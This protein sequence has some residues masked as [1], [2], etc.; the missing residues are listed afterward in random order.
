MGEL[1]GRKPLFPGDDYIKQMN[2]IFDTLGT[3][4]SSDL[5]FISN[6]KALEYIKGL[7]KKM[8]KQWSSI[9]P[10]ANPAAL[11]LLDKMLVFNPHQRITIDEALAHPYLKQLHNPKTE[12]NSKAKFD[13]DFEKCDLNKG[14]IQD[15]MWQEVL[16]F[17]PELRTRGFRRSK[18]D[19]TVVKPFENEQETVQQYTLKHSAQYQAQTQNNQQIQQNTQ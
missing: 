4:N 9:Y 5:T 1:L 7:K 12:P 2:L 11:D 19:A 13:F 17:R 15:L 10:K 6:E 16:Q 3:P 18:E 14:V 8:K